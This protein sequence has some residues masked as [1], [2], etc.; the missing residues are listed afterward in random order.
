MAKSA[1]EA[2]VVRLVPHGA[3]HVVDRVSIFAAIP[4]F[5]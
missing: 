4:D 3:D 1:V 5:D 2:V